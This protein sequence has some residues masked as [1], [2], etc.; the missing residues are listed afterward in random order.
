MAGL[1]ITLSNGRI[2]LTPQGLGVGNRV[3]SHNPGNLI[4]EAK[5]P[6][7]SNSLLLLHP[8]D[9]LSTLPCPAE[10]RRGQLE[11]TILT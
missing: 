5:T 7:P 4:H 8:P 3:T 11:G 9:H 6:L 10:L 1:A 2:R